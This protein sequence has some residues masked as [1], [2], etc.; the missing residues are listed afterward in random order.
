MPADLEGNLCNARRVAEDT[1]V[2][3]I[4]EEHLTLEGGINLCQSCVLAQGI[5]RWHEGVSLLT[6]LTLQDSRAALP[7][8]RTTHAWN[9]S[10]GT[11]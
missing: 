5:Q 11:T 4:R 8:R 2:V 7:R 6:H 1:D 3:K 9:P 10:H